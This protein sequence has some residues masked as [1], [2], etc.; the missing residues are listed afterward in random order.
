MPGKAAVLTCLALALFGRAAAEQPS[1]A[2]RKLI[3]KLMQKEEL[4]TVSNVPTSV[5]FI[6]DND[7]NTLQIVFLTDPNAK[8]KVSDDGEVVF[9]PPGLSLTQHNWLTDEAF[10]RKARR[11]LAGQAPAP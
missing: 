11:I 1:D 8:A 3:N 2:E 10:K 9:V 7:F 4:I 6:A 5:G